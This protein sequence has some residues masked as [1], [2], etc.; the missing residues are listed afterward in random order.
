MA[1]WLAELPVGL[2]D[3]NKARLQPFRNGSGIDSGTGAAG[4]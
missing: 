4:T 3:G 1:G 2:P